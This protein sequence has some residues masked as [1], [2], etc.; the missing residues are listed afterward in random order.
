MSASTVGIL[1]AAGFGTRLRPATDLRPKPLLP[2]AGL[3]PL[4]FAL[5]R[6]SETGLR[7]VVVNS[8][9]LNDQ[10]EAKLRE[11]E[12][13]L[14]KLE[15]RRSV[16]KPE[17]LGTGGAL[18]KIFRDFPDWFEGSSVLVQN[19]DT[20]ARLDLARLVSSPDRN[21]FAISRR[22]EHLA[23]YGP[24]WV[25]GEGA[26]RGRWA[27]AGSKEGA[28]GLEATHFL[29]LHSLS[30]AAVSRL[31]NGPF[32]TR[33]VDLF[34]GVYRPLIREGQS[35]DSVEYFVAGSKDEWFDMNTPEFLLEAQ[36]K[37]LDGLENDRG[38]QEALKA[39]HP[40]LERRSPGVWIRGT[41][42][43]EARAPLVW[44]EDSQG[45][46]PKSTAKAGPRASL[47]A[48]GRAVSLAK[49][50]SIENASLLVREGASSPPRGDL[51]GEVAVW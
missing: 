46:V 5:H 33:A 37:I 43:S 14:P 27:A 12:G 17:I 19:A 49:L 34:D 4:F 35:F 7:K 6:L 15:I 23:K 1:L 38:W 41:G 24:L 29:G 40:G 47:V 39:R 36:A 11:W 28:P 22:A 32:E 50:D 30:R 18:L 45:F 9:H 2:V 26:E 3:E 21:L 10:I 31:L 51:R 42:P 44:V 25:K 20:L 8:H 48:E 13:R 16:E